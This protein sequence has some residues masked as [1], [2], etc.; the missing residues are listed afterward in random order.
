MPDSL[1]GNGSAW[2]GFR[3]RDLL[4]TIPSSMWDFSGIG[5]YPC[6]GDVI[7]PTMGTVLGII[8]TP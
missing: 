2:I 1:N 4:R 8:I 3:I 7:N 5:H 6:P